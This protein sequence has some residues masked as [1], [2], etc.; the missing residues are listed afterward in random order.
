VNQLSGEVATTIGAMGF[1]AGDQFLAT[2]LDPLGY[3][4]ESILGGRLRPQGGDGSGDGQS[5]APNRKRYAVWG[6]AT[7]AY[8]RT[9]GNSTDGSASRTARTAGFVLGFDHLIGA[10]SMAGIAIAV[11]E[12]SASVASGQGTGTANFGQIGAYGST[13][14]GSFTLAGAGAFT[15]MDADTK[16]T[17]Y[18]LGSDQQRASFN[19]QTYS[20]RA[21]LRQDG[22]VAGGFR[23]QPLAAIQWQQVNIGG[24]TESSAAT[25]SSLG[26]TVSGQSQT[27]F[28]TELGGQVQGTALLGRMP[29]QGFA[30]AAWAHYLT[31]DAAMAVGFA[32]LPNAGFTVRGARGDA[33]A[34]LL[35]AGLELPI[36]PGLTLGARVDSELSGN[37][38]QV[39]GTARLRYNF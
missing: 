1:A 23:L 4:R 8:E 27:S 11:G 21:E 17:L 3:G 10:Q 28:R 7:G 33:N 29:V 24:Y 9:T 26:V 20:L 30:R 2:V 31:R 39:A 36:R 22:L 32:S 38:T 35:A 5:D 14:F 19:A 6:S 25:G 15:F 18:F 13:R 37:V 34:A 12:S 16:R